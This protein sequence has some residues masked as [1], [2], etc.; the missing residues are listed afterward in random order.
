MASQGTCRCDLDVPVLHPVQLHCATA[1]LFLPTVIRA[2]ASST[3]CSGGGRHRSRPTISNPHLDI[4]TLQS[5]VQSPTTRSFLR[6][7]SRAG[8]H[9]SIL[10]NRINDSY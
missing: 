4:S 2:A 7:E 1:I 10:G 5:S 8:H 6:S 3:V 9:Y